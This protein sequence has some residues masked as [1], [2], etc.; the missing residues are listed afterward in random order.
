MARNI[1]IKARV[2]NLDRLRQRIAAVATSG[3]ETLEQRDTFFAVPK[4]RLKLREFGNGS[5]E[6]IFYQRND[7]AGPKLSQYFRTDVSD[8][9]SMRTLLSVSLGQRAVVAKRREVFLAGQTRIHL[10]EV[11]GLGR[12]VEIEVVLSTNQSESEGESIARDLMRRLGIQP[13]DLLELAY[14]DMLESDNSATPTW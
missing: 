11:E 8:P 10:D 9:D 5:A 1:E 13:A 6:L 12:F 7:T 4:G 14:V 3:P 2:G